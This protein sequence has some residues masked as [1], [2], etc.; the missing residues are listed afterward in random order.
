LEKPKYQAKPSKKPVPFAKAF[1]NQSPQMQGRRKEKMLA[2]DLD[3]RQQPASGAFPDQ[4]GDVVTENFLIES[5]YT[6]ARSYKITAD[7]LAKVRSEANLKNRTPAMVIE[8]AGEEPWVLL[9]YYAWK[10]LARESTSGI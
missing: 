6:K 10:V 2:R 4:P 5:K 8:I 9:P 1:R 3:G 7:C